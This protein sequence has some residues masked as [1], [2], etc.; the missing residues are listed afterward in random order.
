LFSLAIFSRS[1]SSLDWLLLSLGIIPSLSSSLPCH[2]ERSGKSARA[3]RRRHQ[4]RG[5]VPPPISPI[6]HGAASGCSV[7]T[8]ARRISTRAR[9]G[10]QISRSARNDREEWRRH[11]QV[12]RWTSVPAVAGRDGTLAG[13]PI[14]LPTADR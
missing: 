14:C 13:N 11:R 2:F 9:S 8:G 5:F 1:T 10:A 7:G 4:Q 3:A 6:L 12:V